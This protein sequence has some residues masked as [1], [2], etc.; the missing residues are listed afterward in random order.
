MHFHTN[1]V[2]I[3]QSN[4]I[5]NNKKPPLEWYTALTRNCDESNDSFEALPKLLNGTLNDNCGNIAG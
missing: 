3:S 2:G 1:D 5:A 4:S